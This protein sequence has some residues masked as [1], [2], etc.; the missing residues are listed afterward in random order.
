VPP[1]PSGSGAAQLEICDVAVSA[2][3]ARQ[4]G[5]VQL[6]CSVSGETHQ[7]DKVF[8]QDVKVVSV[9]SGFRHLPAEDLACSLGH[10]AVV[11]EIDALPGVQ[12]EPVPGPLHARDADPIGVPLCQVLGILGVADHHDGLVCAGNAQSLALGFGEGTC[13]DAQGTVSDRCCHTIMQSPESRSSCKGAAAS[14]SFPLVAPRKAWTNTHSRHECSL[15][16]ARL[17]ES[18]ITHHSFRSD[19]LC[20]ASGGPSGTCRAFLQS[21]LQPLLPG[22]T[23]QALLFR[24]LCGPACILGTES[25]YRMCLFASGRNTLVQG[26]PDILPICKQA[27]EDAAK[28]CS[29]DRSTIRNFSSP[30]L[31]NAIVVRLDRLVRSL[32]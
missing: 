13:R 24:R 4:T 12:H 20:R 27:C 25:A 28:R 29:K 6:E 19:H 31:G 26:N 21:T 2:L 32:F 10:P 23:R 9:I 1:A 7:V 18:A 3:S 15:A 22:S 17:A 5:T 8:V 11:L 30:H 14:I 16:D